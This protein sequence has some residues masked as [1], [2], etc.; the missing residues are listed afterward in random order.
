MAAFCDFELSKCDVLTNFIGFKRGSLFQIQNFQP[1]DPISYTSFF[2]NYLLPNLPCLLSAKVTE[3]WLSRKDWVLDGAP[4]F[5]VLK[6]KFGKNVP[7]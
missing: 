4:N 3:N 7:F 1:R 2:Q 6:E 5:E